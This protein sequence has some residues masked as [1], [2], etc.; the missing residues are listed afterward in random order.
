MDTGLSK[1]ANLLASTVGNEVHDRLLL[2][3]HLAHDIADFNFQSSD[4]E[5]VGCVSVAVHAPNLSTMP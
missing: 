5:R 2:N 1:L 3:L 4:G